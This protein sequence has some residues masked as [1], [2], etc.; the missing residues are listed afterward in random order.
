MKSVKKI[1]VFLGGYINLSN[2]QNI[3][4]RSIASYIDK[5]NFEIYSLELYSGNLPS[6]KQDNL[7]IFKCFYPHRISKYL[8]YLWGIYKCDIAFLP[9]GECQGWNRLILNILR[10]KSF[11]TVEGILDEEAINNAISVHGNTKKVVKMYNFYKNLYS[12]TRYMKSYNQTNLQIYSKDKILYLGSEVDYFLNSQ[13]NI[14][15]LNDIILIGN[16][17]LRKGII[18]Y[19]YLATQNPQ[20]TFH[21]V[22]TGNGKIDLAA[23]I[24]E[25]NI[26]N[27]VYHGGLKHSELISLLEQIDL[28]ILPSHSEGFP[29][30]TLET[31]AAGVPSM[32]YSDYGAKEWI[33]DHE[34][35]FVVDTLEQMQEVLNELLVAPELLQS[36]SAN[37]ID[38]AKRFDWKVLI[39]DWENEI[40]TIVKSK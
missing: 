32:V 12:I 22:G 3:N 27:L 25:E 11:S 31:A 30:V 17:L 13:K 8:G 18:D 15:R 36:M 16:D 33:D 28:H 40:I 20:L 39:K 35:G 7:N 9:K 6:L 10:K 37:A 14:E 5:H 19:V 23:K 4:C 26:N 29:K 21:V 34:N 24:K 1:K 2:A 38:L